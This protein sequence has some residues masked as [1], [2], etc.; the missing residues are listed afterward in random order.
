MWDDNKIFNINVDS[1]L[2]PDYGNIEEL[3]QMGRSVS[4]LQSG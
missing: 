3:L 1:I 4:R 2:V